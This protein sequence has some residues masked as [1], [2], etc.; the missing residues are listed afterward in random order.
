V[1]SFVIAACLREEA[2]DSFGV[3]DRGGGFMKDE[4]SRA[5]PGARRNAARR[6]DTR[7]LIVKA[8]VEELIDHGF[9]AL[10]LQ[11]VADRAGIAYGN[12][13]YHFPTKDLLVVA[14]LDDI[15]EGYRREFS[16][17]ASALK[18]SPEEALDRLVEWV[19]EDAMTRRVSRTFTELWAVAN[20]DAA[21]AKRVNRV[22]DDAILAFSNAL[23]VAKSGEAV[24][25]F[26]SGLYFLA[27]LTEGSSVIFGNR[28]RSDREREA[29]RRNVR[30]LVI[31]FLQR[32]HRAAMAA[33]PQ[34]PDGNG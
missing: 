15:L 26:R 31:P 25:A 11:R 17:L 20:V 32:L 6:P 9:A 3:S 4:L 14:M 23:G 10:T 8:A 13:T 2:S 1:A 24:A 27:V 30:E 22:Y 12:L 21:L 19:V 18:E 7:S 28:A 33:H 34:R 16:Q 5:R 29:F